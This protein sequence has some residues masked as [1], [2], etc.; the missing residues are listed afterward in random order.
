[1]TPSNSYEAFLNDT[2]NGVDGSDDSLHDLGPDPDPGGSVDKGRR[3][4][5]CAVCGG[6]DKQDAQVSGRLDQAH[7]FPQGRR[8]LGR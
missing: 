3:G 8:R 4:V 7:D 6:V 1:M 5:P 2:A